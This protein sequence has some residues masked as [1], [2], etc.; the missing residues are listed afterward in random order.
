MHEVFGHQVALVSGDSPPEFVQSTTSVI[1]SITSSTDET[2]LTTGPTIPTPI[3]TTNTTNKGDIIDTLTVLF[4]YR[5]GWRTHLTMFN[6]RII[7]IGWIWHIETQLV[8]RHFKIQVVVNQFIRHTHLVGIEDTIWVSS[9]STS[10]NPLFHQQTLKK[11]NRSSQ[12]LIG[13]C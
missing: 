13:E 4:L 8:N 12:I 3:T 11:S 5:L 6:G 10:K 1:L 2:R 7:F 9:N